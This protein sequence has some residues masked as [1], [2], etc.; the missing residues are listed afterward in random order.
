MIIEKNGSLSHIAI[1]RG[2]SKDIDK[3][4]I[5]AMTMSPKW[6]PGTQNGK[7]V[8]VE[9]AVPISFTLAE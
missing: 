1:A 3:E 8:R 4:A 9:Y 6:K 7:V 5:R 2:L